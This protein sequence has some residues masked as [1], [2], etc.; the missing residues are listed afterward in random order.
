MTELG[1]EWPLRRV[2]K[3]P[4]GLGS[5]SLGILSVVLVGSILFIAIFANFIAPYDP[6][7]QDYVTFLQGP[8]WAHWLGTDHLGRDLLT[9]LMYG[10]RVALLVGLGAVGFAMIVGVT[11]GAV[12]G[13]TRGLLD[14][15]IMRLVD[16]VLSFPSVMLALGIMAALGP[17]LTTIIIAIG[18]GDMPLFARLARSQ[19][20]SV[21]ERDFVTVAH[22][23]GAR[24]PR[25]VLRHILPHIMGPLMALATLQV[26]HAILIEAVLS[27]LGLGVQPPTA[28]W[29]A[30]LKTGFSYIEIA[31]WI[32]IFSGLAILLTVLGI[33]LL[34]DALRDNFDPKSDLN[35]DS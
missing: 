4:F 24:A 23:M 29:G 17:S 22:A 35:K 26:G 9:R 15:A 10:S 34:Q 3:L 12:A 18:V 20:L 16:A 31:P 2:P 27:F 28:S 19:V 8:S 11:L 25:V 13:Y 21:R 33:T 5:S 14:N 30:I 1:Q 32:S 6:N 7:K